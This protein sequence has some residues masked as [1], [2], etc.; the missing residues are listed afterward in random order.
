M[1][2]FLFLLMITFTVMANV[3]AS[4]KVEDY[5]YV[6]IWNSD[7]TNNVYKCADRPTI[8]PTSENLVLRTN[9]TEVLYPITEA[10]KFTFGKSEDY[11]S[12]IKTAET[13]A[14]YE[15]TANMVRISGLKQ[16]TAASI[17]STDGKCMMQKKSSKGEISFNI[18]G[19]RNG[20][21][22]VKCGT[23]TFK[24]LKK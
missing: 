1:K 14:L 24:F 16:S 8:Y 20:V 6:V 13:H 10:R 11:E 21:Y 19:L 22:V 15:I 2:K 7:N 18:T 4:D 3:Y 9:H 5:T 17:F 12:G 23:E